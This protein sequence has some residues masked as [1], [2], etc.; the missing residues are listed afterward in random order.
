VFKGGPP[1]VCPEEG[2]ALADNGLIL[3]NDLVFL[4]NYVFK[5][6]PPP[7]PC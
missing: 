4:V 2:D 5:S 7:P 3:V 1:P 6:G